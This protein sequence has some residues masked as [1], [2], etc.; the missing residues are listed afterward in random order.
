MSI[1]EPSES[2]YNSEN[3][4]RVE[5]YKRRLDD[6]DNFYLDWRNAKLPPRLPFKDLEKLRT[7]LI[8]RVETTLIDLESELKIDDFDA[9]ATDMLEL[10][11][12]KLR[13]QLKE[14]KSSKWIR[15]TTDLEPTLGLG[16]DVELESWDA[17]SVSEL[18]GYYEEWSRLFVEKTLPKQALDQ[19][20][21]WLL[22]QVAELLAA[23]E[24]DLDRDDLD[25]ETMTRLLATR[26]DW[27]KKLKILMWPELVGEPD[28]VL[29][30]PIE[31]DETGMGINRA[32]G[33][34]MSR[35]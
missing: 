35:N 27:T 10:G 25:I 13:Q 15:I 22:K 11:Y 7:W 17:T 14:L 12:E 24:E 32:F 20:R 19:T 21:T 2:D 31:V 4:D 34:R 23:I 1:F 30:I 18:N 8:V 29:P 5:N 26:V 9:G 28:E 3:D 16:D 33:G 6:L